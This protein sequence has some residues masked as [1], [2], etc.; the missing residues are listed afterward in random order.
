MQRLIH[1]IKS[2]FSA[3]DSDSAFQSPSKLKII[4]RKQHGIS[5]KQID[6]E[7]LDVLY[8]LKRAGYDAYLVGGG[9]RDILLGLEPKDFD[10]V[11]NA[12]PE[13]VKGV[14][15][16][17]CRLIGRRFRL[18]HVYF[19]RNAIEVA[20]FRGA[21]EGH[22]SGNRKQVN[23]TRA[24]D[25]T[26]RLVRDNVYGT[27]DED[28]WRRDFT[29]NSLYYDIRNFSVV[30]YTGGME[31][32]RKGQLRLIGDPET[33][34]REDPVRMIRAVRFA[35]KL[36]FDIEQRTKAPIY[37]L[38]HLLKD[39]SHARMFEEV[40]KLFHSGVAVEVFE[41]LRHFGLFTFLFPQTHHLL[42]QESEGFPRMLVIE[43]LKSTDARIQSDKGVN[44]SFLFAAMLWEP[45]LQR[46]EQHLAEGFARQD[47]MFAAASDVIDQQI[48]STSIP[49]RFISQIKEIW[50]LQFRLLNR[51]GNRPQRLSE[52]P[53]FRAAY[54]F[55]GIRVAAG[56]DDSLKEV[57]DWWT[58]YQKL[59][60]VDQ[61]AFA[62]NVEKPKGRRRRPRRNR[63]PYRKR[64]QGRNDQAQTA[65]SDES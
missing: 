39:V 42:S 50:S 65:S 16:S 28:V 4:E 13:Q 31:D 10:V 46:M 58:E 1:K 57:F 43:A 9:V 37:E 55:M 15:K 54:D 40:L 23:N 52:H 2:F 32:L 29:V 64:S 41:K 53:R 35:A 3:S 48:Y 63:N 17:R 8:G 18:A 6:K 45:M 33:R 47:A 60:A 21:G 25:D 36:G 19:G 11:T 59:D 38:G 49:K 26:G 30:D 14:F 61:V 62:N 44:P 7:A 51:H 34:Y 12:E 20:T 5:R 22:Q 24:V 27:I 56:D